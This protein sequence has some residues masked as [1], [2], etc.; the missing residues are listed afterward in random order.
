[1]RE[2]PSKNY[3]I[4]SLMTIGVIIVCLIFNKVYKFSNNKNYSSIMRDFI[5]E[6]QYED[7]DNYLLENLDVV[8]YINDNSTKN[9][10]NLEKELKKIITNNGISQYVVYIEKSEDIIKKYD[11][12]SNSPIFIAYQNGIVTEILS[13]PYYTSEEIQE[14][15]VRNKV[16]DND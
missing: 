4:L 1:M 16:I 6:I 8:L 2:I 14:F 13:K 3:I 11:L 10:Q 15:L 5:S 7:L 9:D 12:D